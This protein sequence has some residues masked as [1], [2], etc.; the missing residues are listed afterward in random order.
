MEALCGAVGALAVA[1]A[2]GAPLGPLDEAVNR[3]SWTSA[4]LRGEPMPVI[5]EAPEPLPEPVRT[6]PASTPPPAIIP[7]PDRKV[8]TWDP[9]TPLERI[10][11]TRYRALLLEILKR[12][13]HDWILYRNHSKLEMRQ[14]AETAHTWL[15]KEKPGHPWWAQ[16]KREGHTIVAFLV[17]CET[18]DLDPEYVR[19]RARQTTV[20]QI[21]TAGRPA[22]RRRPHK[23]VRYDEHRVD[24]ISI[25]ALEQ[26][27]GGR[28]ESDYQQHFAAPTHGYV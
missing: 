17:I 20:K 27:S 14:R 6:R 1:Q 26:P 3:L 25:E 8:S 18:C 16:R 13:I 5:E 10:E 24:T 23:E 19:R 11:V 7:Q 2:L 28:Y 4:V 12:A 15:F 22:E 21:M 9:Q